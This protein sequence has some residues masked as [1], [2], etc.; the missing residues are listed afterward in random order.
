MLDAPTAL[1]VF[2]LLALAV[3]ALRRLGEL[4]VLRVRGGRVIPQRGRLPRAL[5][6]D[7]EEIAAH[8]PVARAELRIVVENGRPMLRATGL[9]GVQLQRMRNCV[10]LHPLSRFRTSPPVRRRWL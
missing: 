9:S 7:L 8:P 1:L 5:L 2:T 6:A 10:G 3:V 4:C